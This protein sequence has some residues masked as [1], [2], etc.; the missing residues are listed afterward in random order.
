[1][2]RPHSPRRDQAPRPLTDAAPR[3][4]WAIPIVDARLSGG[5]CL[6]VVDM[7][8]CY[9]DR[10]GML[11]LMLRDDRNVAEYYFGRLETTVVPRCLSLITEFRRF[12]L[13][14]YYVTFGTNLPDG[15][16]LSPRRRRRR[17]LM[18]AR[19]GVSTPPVVGTVE[20]EIVAALA[21]SPSDIVLNKL[22]AS[23]FNSTALEWH[24]RQRG[25]GTVVIV[26]VGTNGCVEGAARDAADLGLECL[27]VDDATATFDQQ[28][29]DATMTNCARFVGG[30]TT[31]SELIKALAV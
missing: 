13:P 3:F 18:A 11:D 10:G 25:I 23:P 7:Q 30:V 16:D 6:L 17:E 12:G 8:R 22:S 20:H 1:M 29:H 5:I 21:P 19:F 31:T 28:S 14:I 24:L 9:V 15:S 27:V 26:G 2:N 4:E